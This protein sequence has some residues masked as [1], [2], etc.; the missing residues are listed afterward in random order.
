MINKK[1]VLG[2]LQDEAGMKDAVHV[3]IVSVRAACPIK[4]G[5]RCTMD[6][7][8]EA[9]PDEDGPGIA[10]P[11]LKSNIQTG[12]TFW[13]LL[14]QDEIPN[15]RHVWEHPDIDFSAP[16]VP[17]KRNRTI[18]EFAKEFGVEYDQLMK[19]LATVVSTGRPVK[20]KKEIPDRIDVYDIWYEWAEEVGYEFENAGTACCPEYEYPTCEI[21]ESDPTDRD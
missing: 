14:N 17:R 21:Y 18:E 5:E 11:F 13:L 10:D 15:V 4:R 7:N 6:K 12:Q 3:A 8:R 2:K 1:N 16:A 20:T 19:D 9:Q